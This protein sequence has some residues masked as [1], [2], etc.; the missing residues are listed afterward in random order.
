MKDKGEKTVLQERPF[1]YCSD[2]KGLIEFVTLEWNCDF[3]DVSNNIGR[4]SKKIVQTKKG[5][6]VS[7]SLKIIFINFSIVFLK[8]FIL[9]QYYSNHIC[10]KIHKKIRFF[11]VCR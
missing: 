4:A 3:P 1:S 6:S 5:G 9:E 11:F 8:F 7:I 10:I 2:I